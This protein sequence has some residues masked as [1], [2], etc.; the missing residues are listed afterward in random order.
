MFENVPHRSV[1]DDKVDRQIAD[2]IGSLTDPIIVMPGGWGETLPA[3]IKG[4]IKMERLIENVK[5]IKGEDPTGTD[6]EAVAYL[7]TASLT[8]PIS[9]DWTE[10]YL[11]LAGKVMAR[12]RK[13]EIPPDIKVESLNEYQQNEL[14]R[15]KR[16]LYATRVQARKDKDKTEHKQEKEGT[17]GKEI[18]Q[19]PLFD[20]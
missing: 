2:L 13:T 17:R 9:S 8:A 11:Y 20:F 5:Q 10:I 7:Y 1:L 19:P 14:R 15:L 16:W 6:A 3:W 12:H 18:I 4:A